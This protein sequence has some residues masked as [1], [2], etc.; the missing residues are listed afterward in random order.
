MTRSSYS[1]TGIHL[2]VFLLLIVS[3]CGTASATNLTGTFKNPD[4]TLVNGKIIFLLN[5]PARLN[6]QSAQ[7]VPMVKIFAITN[8]AL[9]AGAFVYGNDVLVPGGTYYLVR[10]VDNSNNLLFEQKWSISGVN[11]NLGSLTPTTTGVVFPDPLIKNLATGQA[12]QGPVSF[13]APITA[14]S[15]TLNGNLNPGAADS[16]D[17]GS[18]SA[19]WQEL[20]AQRW[21]S[22]HAVSTT[23]G[24]ALPPAVAPSAAVFSSG[25]SIA[26]GTYYFKITYFNKNGETTASPVGTL[27]VSSG[28]TNRIHV[29][30]S[31]FLW[32]SGCYGYLVYA[33]NDN[34]NFYVQTPSGLISDF[35]L[36][37]PGGKTGHYVALGSYGARFP[38]LTFSGSAPPSSNTAMIDPLQVA[39]NQEMR[40]TDY[41]LA[42]GTLLIGSNGAQYG[43]VLTTPL[44]VSRYARI[45]GTSHIGTHG[46][47][48]GRIIANFADTKLAGVMQFGGFVSFE[49][50]DFYST[51]NALM[52]LSGVGYQG[53]SYSVINS[54][55]RTTD[56]TGTYSALRLIGP[57]YNVHGLNN[58]FRGG[59]AAVRWTNGAG[60]EIHLQGGRWD[61]DKQALVNTTGWTD[62]DN[63]ANDAGFSNAIA[64]VS[65]KDI[66]FEQ[67]TAILIDG[68]NMGVRIERCQFA[69]TVT[70]GGTDSLFKMGSDAFGS[71]SK[72]TILDSTMPNSANARVGLNVVSNIA[73]APS[74]EIT[75]SGTGAGSSTGTLQ[76]LDLNNKIIFVSLSNA[77]LNFNPV[78]AQYTVLNA[79]N[80]LTPRW[81]GTANPA[82]SGAGKMWNE[83][84]DR[85]VLSSSN[86]SRSTRKSFFMNGNVL[87][88][89]QSD[90]STVDFDIHPTSGIMN[91]RGNMRIQAYAGAA[92]QFS[93]GPSSSTA[94][95]GTISLVNQ[96]S[97]Y[98]RNA[99]NN[100]DIRLVAGDGS[101]RA[102]VG[103][104]A[105]VCL[106]TSTNCAPIKGN[107]SSTATLDFPNTAISG[108]S[109]LP[110]TVTG[111]TVGDS[112][113]L[114]VL[115]ASVPAGGSYFAWVSAANTVT[116]RFC[117]DG[118]ARDPASG[119]FRATV[120]RF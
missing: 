18:S 99:A 58:Y 96:G 2:C 81:F 106:S 60:G 29:V 38:S 47:A 16:Y 41:A 73:S 3:F 79:D 75:N 92:A 52:L 104:A 86:S 40:Q 28:S 4:G 100:A 101:D 44:I 90:D 61:L 55:I 108:C 49:N 82:N 78:A 26:A 112:V 94:A 68:V 85:I 103:D 51:G 83:F 8:G 22:M 117:A 7:I 62:P 64:L 54:S 43:Y 17:L 71:G 5:Q 57:I 91:L 114:G 56:S 13:A 53:Q 111:A 116:V 70:A 32:A 88:L 42:G 76:A 37:A 19:P 14:F 23:G 119:S 31:D 77:T 45:I 35:Q 105:G 48:Q 74:L 15:L 113:F 33:S 67:G 84:I 93:I 118:T 120:V 39:L 46:D 9:E 6:D 63:G 89:R 50:L 65:L 34:V 25:G 97:M 27:T 24:T 20:H 95:G 1:H 98:M 36:S 107:L 12:V 110:M 30:P 80:T 102:I 72:W 11:L 109:D 21:N 87:E 69:D 59:K 66:L 115:N 10:L